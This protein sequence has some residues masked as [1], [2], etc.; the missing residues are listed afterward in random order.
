M[1]GA[2]DSP[3][4]ESIAEYHTMPEWT[5]DASPPTEQEPAAMPKSDSEDEES[6]LEMVKIQRAQVLNFVQDPSKQEAP[7]ATV[8]PSQLTPPD[9][10]TVPE[11]KPPEEDRDEDFHTPTGSPTSTGRLSPPLI[12][13]QSYPR[14][15]LIPEGQSN[16]FPQTMP[17]HQCE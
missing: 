9:F 10:P 4:P 6:Y 3:L 2:G 8:I 16:V 1:L 13:L 7:K 17:R 14:E 12:P 5:A 11:S 15:R